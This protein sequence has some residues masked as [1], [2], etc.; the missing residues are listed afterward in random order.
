M[1]SVFL[2][3]PTAESLEQLGAFKRFLLVW[4]PTAIGVAIIVVESQPE[5]S[6][7]NTSAWLRPLWERWFGKIS[8]REWNEF[9]HILRKTGHFCF[10]GLLCVL[11]VRGWLLTWARN[12]RI[13]TLAWR[14]RSWLC[15]VGST[16]VVASGDEFHQT[17]L[18][19]RTGLFSDVV[20]DTCGGIV[21]SGAVAGVSWW[22]RRVLYSG[23]GG[24]A[25]SGSSSAG[26]DHHESVVEARGG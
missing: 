22:L 13:R 6:A 2:E 17:F 10:Y 26:L 24:G 12:P 20:I 14:W 1:R 4:T 15:G 11:F 3:R 16:L 5:F 18:P 23:S 8:T 19:S 25:K 21:I 9:H 7:A